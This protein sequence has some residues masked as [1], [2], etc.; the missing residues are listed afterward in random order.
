[1]FPSCPLAFGFFFDC[2]SEPISLYSSN[3]SS[4]QSMSSPH[5]KLDQIVV[6]TIANSVFFDM[7]PAERYLKDTR[8]TVQAMQFAAI[9]RIQPRTLADPF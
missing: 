6:Q 8:G 9:A 2:H 3:R 5:P 4:D 7:P 1:M